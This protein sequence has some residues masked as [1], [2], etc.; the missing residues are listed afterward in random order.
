MIHAE[1]GGRYGKKL[2]AHTG[3]PSNPGDLHATAYIS[4]AYGAS[5]GSTIKSKVPFASDPT[6]KTR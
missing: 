6:A 2:R 1:K 3:H 4:T 5:N